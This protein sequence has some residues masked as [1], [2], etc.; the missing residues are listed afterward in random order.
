MAAV[1]VLY[2]EDDEDD[3]K[4]TRDLLSGEEGNEFDLDWVR[5]Y[6]DAIAAIRR[7]GYDA[8][9]LDYCL[10]RRS[11]LDL[12]CGALK[13][14]AIGPVVIVTEQ[15]MAQIDVEAK[16]HGAAGFL[17][18]RDLTT[19]SLTTTL[20]NGIAAHTSTTAAEQPAAWPPVP[21]RLGRL[22]AVLGSKGG[23]GTSTIVAN[24]AAS[25][26]RRR[27][28]ITV[29]EMRGDHGDLTRLLDVVAFQNISQ[30]LRTKPEEID[31][32][33]FEAALSQGSNGMRVLAA[34]LS[35]AEY[36]DIGET[37]AQAIIDAAVRTSDLVVVDLPCNASVANRRV[38][39]SA[40]AVAM[41]VEREPAAIA[42]AHAILSMLRA[43]QIPAPVG[44]VIVSRG[45]APESMSVAEIGSE[46]GVKKYGAI[47]AAAE[48]FYK[49]AVTR[50]PVVT[51]HP[52]HPVGRAFDE[53]A[54]A[55]M[56]EP[57]NPWRASSPEA[58]AG[59]ESAARATEPVP[60]PPAERFTAEWPTQSHTT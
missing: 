31:D 35:A 38:L 55:M 32:A 15:D 24:I 59:G 47:P 58:A 53:V 57:Q 21:A 48:L 56:K 19:E 9:L 6:E 54:T 13:G 18:K 36:G 42:S 34:P 22:L 51:G 8:Y 16:K 5:T 14:G 30:L 1:R 37:H 43:W 12:L 52:A 7:G 3:F 45:S 17:L 20:R 60:S 28:T 4:I 41:V 49:S 25:L 23:V 33:C 26:L 11:G 44:S 46:L 29:I 27:F 50:I 2:V 10:G 39:A 40:D